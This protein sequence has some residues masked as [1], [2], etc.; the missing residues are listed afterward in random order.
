M[1]TA[2]FN[3]KVLFVGFVNSPSLVFHK[4]TFYFLFDETDCLLIPKKLIYL[5]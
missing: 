1:T 3:I 5:L 4:H 2:P